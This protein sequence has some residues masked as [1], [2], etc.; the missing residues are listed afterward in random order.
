MCEYIM[1][2]GWRCGA[3]ALD[4]LVLEVERVG[5]SWIELECVSWELMVGRW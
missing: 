1:V 3:G 2:G 5:E 4:W